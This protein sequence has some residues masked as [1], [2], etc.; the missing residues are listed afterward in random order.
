[1]AVEKAKEVHPSLE[2]WYNTLKTDKRKQYAK[3]LF[4]TIESFHFDKSEPDAIKKK[5]DLYVQGIIA[6]EKLKLR[7]SLN[8]LAK[9]KTVDDLRLSKI[10]AD[11]NDLEANLYF[12]LRQKE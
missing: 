10:F 2:E 4:G 1:M 8:E 6:F 5:K 11:L 3:E 7:D 9:I 12:T